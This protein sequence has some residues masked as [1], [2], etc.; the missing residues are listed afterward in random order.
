MGWEAAAVLME[1]LK[2]ESRAE[3]VTEVW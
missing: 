2:A 1:E 3:E